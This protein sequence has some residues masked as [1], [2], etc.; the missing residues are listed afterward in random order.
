[1]NNKIKWTGALFLL[2]NGSWV[3]AAS[4][5]SGSQVGDQRHRPRVPP[6]PRRCRR[7]PPISSSTAFPLTFPAP[8]GGFQRLVPL[9]HPRQ[10]DGLISFHPNTGNPFPS[11]ANAGPIA[12]DSQTVYFRLDPRA[13]WSDGQAGNRRRLH[14]RLRDDAL[15][16]IKGPWFN[17]YYTTEVVAVEKIDDPHHPGEG[18]QPQG[19]AGSPQHHRA[20]APAQAL[21]QDTPNWVKRVQ[22]GCGPDHGPLCDERGE[23]GQSPSPSASRRIGGQKT[24]VTTSTDST[25]AT[26]KV[27]VIRDHN[28][29][30]RHFLK[31]NSTPSR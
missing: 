9:L 23:E 16:D 1:M 3:W 5:P 31:G 7:Q 24:I 4:L 21:L 10:P 15:K 11:L 14:L 6:L 13:K 2:V 20:V 30:F 29:A 17:N 12:P 28:I 27:R 19:Q 26:I 18:G 22:L 25:S 8:W